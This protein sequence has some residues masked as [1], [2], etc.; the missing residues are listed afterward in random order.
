[1]KFTGEGHEGKAKKI[2]A[3]GQEDYSSVTEKPNVIVLDQW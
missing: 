3:A 2:F 1:M